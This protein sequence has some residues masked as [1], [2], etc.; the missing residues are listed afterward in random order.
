MGYLDDDSASSTSSDKMAICRESH[1]GNDSDNVSSSSTHRS[2]STL[3]VDLG[4]TSEGEKYPVEVSYTNLALSL[5]LDTGLFNLLD[6]PFSMDNL[7]RC[8]LDYS[9]SPIPK[10]PKPEDAQADPWTR[11]VVGGEPSPPFDHG[12][13]RSQSE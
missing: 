11:L 13:I 12:P 6:S 8:P 4:G 5:G 10:R 2:Q 7:S 3:Q 1:N 9:K